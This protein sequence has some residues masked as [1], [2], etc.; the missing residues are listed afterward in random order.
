MGIKNILN[1]KSIL[2]VANG[3][4]K[5]Q[6]I[7]RLVSGEVSEDL[8]ASALNLHDNVTIIV[9]EEAASLIDK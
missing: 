7:A 2:L 9:D 1:A 5:A 4:N 8:P 3:K 6:A